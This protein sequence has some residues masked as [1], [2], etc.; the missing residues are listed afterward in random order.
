MRI[1]DKLEKKAE[2]AGKIVGVA[3]ERRRIGDADFVESYLRVARA[4]HIPRG[5]PI[6]PF[7]PGQR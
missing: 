5:R 6:S 2:I 7:D 4:P 3:G 1:L